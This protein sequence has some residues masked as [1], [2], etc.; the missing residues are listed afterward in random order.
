MSELVVRRAEAGDTREI[1]DIYNH[2]VR[3]STVT[4]STIETSET[5]RRTWLEE[6]DE[7]HPVLVAERDGELAGWGSASEWSDRCGWK[8]TVEFSVYVKDGVTQ[9]GV[10]S[11]ILDGL[12]A[13]CRRAGHHAALAQIVADNVP[14]LKMV[15]R[16]GFERI[17]VMQEVGY[18]FD[19]WL[20]LVLV[21]LLLETELARDKSSSES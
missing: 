13:E 4:F 21:E 12:I 15:E 18:K 7:A 5:E 20:D 10:G 16:A 8:H 3:T 2:Y 1:N 6:H 14:C 17:G 19:H 11:A 9:G